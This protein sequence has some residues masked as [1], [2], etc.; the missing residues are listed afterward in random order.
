MGAVGSQFFAE[1]ILFSRRPPMVE[2][3]LDDEMVLRYL[4]S[5]RDDVV[6]PLREPVQAGS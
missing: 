4:R 5:H 2:D 3:F 6:Q 1:E